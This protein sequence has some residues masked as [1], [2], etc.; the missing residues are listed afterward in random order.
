MRASQVRLV[1]LPLRTLKGE[2]HFARRLAS[3]R[4]SVGGCTI[5]G[6]LDGN[7]LSKAGLHIQDRINLVYTD[8]LYAFEANFEII[9]TYADRL[10]TGAFA[11]LEEDSILALLHRISYKQDVP[12]CASARVGAR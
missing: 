10:K 1:N 8:M 9:S 11:A 2:G 12:S 7:Y 3:G 5:I 6:G 4:V